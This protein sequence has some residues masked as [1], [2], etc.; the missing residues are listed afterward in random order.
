MKKTSPDRISVVK[1]EETNS[2]HTWINTNLSWETENYR[3]WGGTQFFPALIQ[4][5]E[6]DRYRWLEIEFAANDGSVN[7]DAIDGFFAFLE[8]NALFLL[9]LSADSF[10]FSGGKLQVVDLESLFSLQGSVQDL[11]SQVTKKTSV[12][13]D[14]YEKQRNYILS[15]LIR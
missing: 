6:D 13:L 3:R 8:A 9:D 10:L 1:R 15:R 5:G 11:I 2:S 12:R 4:A 7:R 14:S